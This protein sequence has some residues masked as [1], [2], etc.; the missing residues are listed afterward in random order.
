GT[1]GKP[2][3]AGKA[4]M[5]G[6]LAALLVREGYGGPQQIIEGEKGFAAATA[7]SFNS[8]LFDDMGKEYT[9]MDVTHKYYPSCGHT[10]AAIDAA[11]GIVNAHRVRPEEI[12]QIK[13]ETYRAALEVAGNPSPSTPYE[14]KFSLPYC[15]AAAVVYGEPTLADF[16]ESKLAEPE[17]RRLMDNTF[18]SVDEEIQAAF[19]GKRGARVVIGTDRGAFSHFVSCR[20]GDPENPLTW[21]EIKHK[22]HALAGPCLKPEN[23]AT[24]MGLVLEID[25]FSDVSRL[26]GQ[27]FGLER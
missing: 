23:T 12:K 8:T 15:I 18:L 14:A 13:V 22:F 26:A 7:G 20:R 3:H 17:I 4:A 9:I 6:V 5:N 21:S 2:L 1:M 24:V 11:L 27:I 25:R 16:T 10:H 19:P